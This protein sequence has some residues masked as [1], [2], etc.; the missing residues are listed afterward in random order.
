MN[1]ISGVGGPKGGGRLSLCSL[2]SFCIL[3]GRRHESASLSRSKNRTSTPLQESLPTPLRPELVRGR[4]G[5]GLHARRC[6]RAGMTADVS[7]RATNACVKRPA[8]NSGHHATLPS[9]SSTSS[10]YRGR[11]LHPPL[12]H[13]GIRITVAEDEGEDGLQQPEQ[14]TA[15]RHQT[16]PRGE[17]GQSLEFEKEWTRESR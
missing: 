6:L 17:T 3:R 9:N 10:A 4:R 7:Y 1:L 15:T 16:G 13:V 14:Q 12:V 2:G 11:S 8:A 5:Y